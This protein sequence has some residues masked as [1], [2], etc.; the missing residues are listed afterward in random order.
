VRTLLLIIFSLP[1]F[2]QRIEAGVK[3]GVPVTSAFQTGS[4][5]TLGFGEAASSATRRYTA[6]PTVELQLAHGFAFEFDVLYKRLG[7]ADVSKNAAFIYTYANT[8]ANSWEFPLLG[9]YRLPS[10]RGIKAYASA[11]PSFRTLS[12]VS[13]STTTIIDF[14][15]GTVTGPVH[16]TG[17][18]HLDA[19]SSSGI[20]VGC[21]TTFGG[22]RFHFSPEVR[23]TRWR[24]DRMPDPELYSN[25]NQVEI[26]LGITL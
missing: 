16:S 8:S 25:Q 11:G 19:R 5:F 4:F 10:I 12:G 1:C 3:G 18:S 21:G 7:L 2:G 6:G 24:S 22:G 13:V 23:Y 9:K 26:L 15:G 20:A 17:D 14:A